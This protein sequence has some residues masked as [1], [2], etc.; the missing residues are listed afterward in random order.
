VYGQ[1]TDYKEACEFLTVVIV[2]AKLLI[3]FCGKISLLNL[4]LF[5]FIAIGAKLNSTLISKL[6]A[7]SYLHYEIK[8]I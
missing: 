8:E 2:E 4:T 7:N 3:F 5:V 1:P 6:Y